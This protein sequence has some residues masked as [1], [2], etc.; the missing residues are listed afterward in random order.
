MRKSFPAAAVGCVIVIFLGLLVG[1]VGML[2]HGVK[3]SPNDAPPAKAAPR[4]VPLR[5]GATQTLVEAR[6]GFTTQVTRRFHPI[7]ILE[8]PPEADVV[9]YGFPAAGGPLKAY[10]S[11]EPYDGRRHPAIVWA[12]AGFKG[13][14]RL[15]WEKSALFRK[16]GF[17]VLAPSYRGEHANRGD[18]QMFFGEVDDLLAA[19]DHIARLPFVDAARV[20]LVGQE[21]GGTLALL[22]ATT[23][24]EKMRA[25][26]AIGGAVDLRGKPI[27]PGGTPLPFPLNDE[28]EVQLR[29]PEPFASA[30]RRPSFYFGSQGNADTAEARD[31]AEAA[32]KAGAPVQV[33]TLRD[34]AVQRIVPLLLPHLQ[35][36]TSPLCTIDFEKELPSAID[37]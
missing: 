8:A 5:P 2:I 32:R 4:Q 10:L 16:H 14:D 1:G 21:E 35:A 18:F 29:S 11:Q 17:I 6:Q 22:A 26:F 7:R 30:I 13:I 27:G 12:H 15:E 25:V 36:D 9:D 3:D 28:R 24:T 19:V 33:V 37:R 34:T 31:M 20:Y 23:G